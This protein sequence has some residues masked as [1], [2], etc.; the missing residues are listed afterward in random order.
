MAVPDIGPLPITV[1]V[2]PTNL[3]YQAKVELGKLVSPMADYLK[4]IRSHAR[5]AIFQML[6]L[7]ILASLLSGSTEKSEDGRLQRCS[8]PHFI[9]TCS[10][11]AEPVR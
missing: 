10:G 9:H 5:P 1:P 7:P 6:A 2:P 3:N 4:T 11:T 8:T